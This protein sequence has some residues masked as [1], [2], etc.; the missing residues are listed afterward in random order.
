V[1]T[2]DAARPWAEA[3]A[4]RGGK[5]A[6]VGSDREV[7]E[8]IGPRTTVIDLEGRMVLPGFHDSHVH[9]VTGGIERKECDLNGI[10]DV[11]GILAAIRRYV[12]AHP[13]AHWVRGGGWE[14]TLFRDGN[15]HKALLDGVVSDRPVALTAADGHSLWVNSRALSTAGIDRDTP[16]PPKGRIERDPETGEPS[17][18][19][20]ESAM[21]LVEL[22]PHS[23]EE[24]LAGAR[25]GLRL[26][27]Q[28][29]I[30]S[31]FEASASQEILEAYFV[32]DLYGELTAR[33]RAAITIDPENPA[34]EVRAIELRRRLRCGRLRPEAVKIFADGV[35]EA[36]TAAMV[37]P[38]AD[39]AGDRGPEE[40]DAETLAR[41]AAAFD[42]A[43]FQIHVHA[44]GDRAVRSTLDA[45]E[46]ARAANGPRDARPVLAHIQV[47][48]PDDRPRFRALGAI[49]C[50][51]PFW[52]YP[53]AYI[54]ELTEPGLGP[55]R[56]RWIY[57]IGSVA[58]TGAALAFGSD[59]SVSS[60]NPLDGIQ[61]AVTRRDPASSEGPAW[62][63]DERIDLAAA[64]RAATLG[65]AFAAFQ[66]STTGSL[67]VG[68]AADLVVL[69]RNLFEIP[70][71]EIG[72]ARV[73]LTLL[74]GEVVWRDPSFEA[75]TSAYGAQRDAAR[76]RASR[77]PSGS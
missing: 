13:A 70:P 11:E 53:D 10:G 66:E 36:R 68:K 61:V 37:E 54:T 30:T 22:P 2:V 59:W 31:L 12:E 34:E 43:G 24:F 65:G 3:V 58:R 39:R 64:L 35:I 63:P 40:P 9:P 28:F 44:I 51:Q 67:E 8:W 19:L 29:G 77:S 47:I 76:R 71:S 32:L 7:E 46:R 73:L 41:A 42:R 4:V 72:R 74:E 69:D 26:A 20:R 48:H 14:L 52:A 62:L 75:T 56:S 25:E 49:A 21:D 16:D 60:M 23:Q 17:G 33:V 57:P 1:Y 45:F 15:P 6:A 5:I 18:T 27:A 50:F 38:Y 55:E